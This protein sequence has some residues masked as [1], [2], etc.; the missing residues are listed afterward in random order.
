M[1]EE[2]NEETV[3]N[4]NVAN[5]TN[6]SAQTVTVNAG[7]SANPVKQKKGNA[8]ASLVLGICSIVCCSIGGILGIIGLINGIVGVKKKQKKGLAVTGIVLSSLGIVVGLIVFV[9]TIIGFT[10]F[11]ST[12][13]GVIKF[14]QSP[15]GQ[16]IGAVL[17]GIDM[18]EIDPD[19]LEESIKQQMLEGAADAAADYLNEQISS[20][21]GL[22]IHDANGN[23]YIIQGESL[24]E[25]TIVDESTGEEINVGEYV[26]AIQS[27]KEEFMTSLEEE[28]GI[29]EDDLTKLMEE[30]SGEAGMEVDAETWGMLLDMLDDQ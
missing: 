3:S 9:G 19:N 24:S 4:E 16:G 17:S 29:T 8:V 26:D 30:M 14:A 5:G 2:L 13:I 6:A 7:Q 22:T 27:G 10:M 15:A 21:D 1:N 20:E 18:N 12:I 11:G 25:A 28:Y 23:E